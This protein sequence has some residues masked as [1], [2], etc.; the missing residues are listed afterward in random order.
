MHACMYIIHIYMALIISDIVICL[1][2][3]MHIYCRFDRDLRWR[4]GVQLIPIVC[5]SSNQFKITKPALDEA[6]NNAQKANIRVKGVL[7][8]NPSNPLGTLLDRET[9]TNLL[10][11][12]N[13]NSIH[14]VC[15][16][17]YGA[18]VFKRPNFISISEV[19]EEEANHLKCNKD[20]IHIV[21]SLSKDLGLPGFRVGIIYS[22]NDN[23]VNCGRKM[24]SFGLVSAQTQYLIASM[25]MD[26]EFVGKFLEESA[27]RLRRRYECFIEGLGKEGIS[28]LESNAGLFCWMDLRQ[29]LEE[30]TIEAEM[31]LWQTI[32]HDVKLNVSPGS[33]FHCNEPGWFRVCFASMEEETMEVALDR[34]GCFMRKTSMSRKKKK[35]TKRKAMRKD[36]LCISFPLSV[37]G[38]F[39]EFMSISPHAMSPHS[40]LVHAPTSG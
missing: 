33:S 6:Y 39:E 5:E 20:L 37:R 27:M 12:T 3:F 22:Y 26:D 9:L 24:S 40:P 17:I 7:I 28:C 16:E 30:A 21:Y 35:K 36:Q 8:T 2:L 19:I 31:D 1:S 32:I 13:A 25:L 34:I 23:V 4:T 29:L 14:L 11:F 15:D 10:S 18:T 38:G